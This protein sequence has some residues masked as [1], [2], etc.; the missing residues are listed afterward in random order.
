[1]ELRAWSVVIHVFRVHQLAFCELILVCPSFSGQTKTRTSLRE[2]RV[3]VV[4]LPP[5]A[6][7]RVE[8]GG[9]P[10]RAPTEPYER[11]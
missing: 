8:L 7:F 5:F 3:S 4:N 6:A 1:M 11:D 2:L 9:C 10:P